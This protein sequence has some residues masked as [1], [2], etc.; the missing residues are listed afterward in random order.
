MRENEKIMREMV[1][2]FQKRCNE[3]VNIQTFLYEH[4][5]YQEAGYSFLFS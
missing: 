4:P 1:R 3:T 5:G 2:G